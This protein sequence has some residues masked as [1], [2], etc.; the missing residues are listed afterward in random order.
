[1]DAGADWAIPAPAVRASVLAAA[2]P[3]ILTSFVPSKATNCTVYQSSL[4]DDAKRV[5]C[6][7]GVSELKAYKA[8]CSPPAIG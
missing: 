7:P 5:D 8:L 1:M 4:F 3:I 2:F 6:A